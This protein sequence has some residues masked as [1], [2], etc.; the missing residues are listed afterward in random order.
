LLVLGILSICAFVLVLQKNNTVVNE[1]YVKNN[2]NIII[3]ILGNNIEGLHGNT[4]TYD[5]LNF[6]L[7]NEPVFKNCDKIFILNRIINSTEKQQYID[8]L[9]QYSVKYIDIPFEY[10]KFNKLPKYN[11][12]SSEI[13]KIKNN[14]RYR[15]KKL[16]NLLYRH[17]L[18]I[19]NNNG[20]RNSAINYGKKHNYKWTFVF[21]SNQYLTQQQYDNI[22]NNID[23][24]DGVKYITIPQLRLSDG[25]LTNDDIINNSDKLTE[26]PI[27]EHQIAFKNSANEKFND[28]LPYGASPKAEFLRRLGVPG[29]WQLWNDGENL[30]NIPD[31]KSIKE[32]WKVLGSVYRLHPGNS[33]NNVKQNFNK[34]LLGLHSMVA[35]LLNN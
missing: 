10:D 8:L 34:R 24:T 5:N 32:K 35:K 31:R 17:N 7:L 25:G 19:V 27:Q 14:S 22:M 28:K 3:R 21:D 18:Y 4:Q 29:K 33:S 12:D 16:M 15:S 20:A 23:D 26:L 11:I 6:T 9:N 13:E 30:Y 1:K 2:H